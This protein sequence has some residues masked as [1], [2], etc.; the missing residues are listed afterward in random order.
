M[1]KVL[2][3]QLIFESVGFFAASLLIRQR[4]CSSSPVGHH[5]LHMRNLPTIKMLLSL[6]APRLQISMFIL[7]GS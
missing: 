6:L 2:S 1:T 7:E 3:R 5:K 4:T